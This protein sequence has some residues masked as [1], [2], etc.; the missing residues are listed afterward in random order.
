MAKEW[1]PLGIQPAHWTVVPIPLHRRKD[2]GFNQSEAL[3]RG[4]AEIT[5]MAIADV[6]AARVP[7]G[8][9]QLNRHQRIRGRT[10]GSLTRPSIP[11]GERVGRLSPP[12][13]CGHDRLHVGLGARPRHRSWKGPIGFITLLDAIR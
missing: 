2:G 12:R 7:A 9:T 8:L 6:L 1:T 3:A 5:G 11:L 4:W 13:R 10:C